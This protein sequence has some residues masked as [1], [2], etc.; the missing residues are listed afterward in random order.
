MELAKRVLPDGR[1][2]VVYKQ[3]TNANLTISSPESYRLGFYDDDY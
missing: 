1:I 3:I 2:L